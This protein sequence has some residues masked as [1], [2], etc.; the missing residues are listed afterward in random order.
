MALR[1]LELL[2]RL[3]GNVPFYV[4]R[5]TPTPAA[6]DAAFRMTLCDNETESLRFKEGS[7]HED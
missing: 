5:C 7:K 4:L 6:F 3:M 2:D 1:Q